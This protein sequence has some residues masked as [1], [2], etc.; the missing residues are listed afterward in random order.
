[1]A[2]GGAG[3]YQFYVLRVAALGAFVAF[4]L[5]AADVEAKPAAAA[6]A[7]LNTAA[8]LDACSADQNVTDE[9]GFADGKITPKAYC[10]CV[11]GK[12]EENKLSQKDVDMLTKM[13]KDE[14]SDAD[15]A[16]YPTLEDLLTANEGYEDACKKS[17]GLPADTGTDVEEAPMEEDAVPD[18]EAPDEGVPPGDDASPP[19]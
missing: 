19:E 4:C 6:T 13:H 11:V 12:F 2:V 18:E 5:Y 16:S 1:M 7:K 17:L 8:F 14:I 10:E 15:A 3:M 9:P